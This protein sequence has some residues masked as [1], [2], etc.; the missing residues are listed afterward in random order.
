MIPAGSNNNIV[1]ADKTIKYVPAKAVLKHEVG[2]EIRLS[3][4]DFSLLAEAYFGDV[5]SKFL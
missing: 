1:G 3:E 2:D 4:A 5:E